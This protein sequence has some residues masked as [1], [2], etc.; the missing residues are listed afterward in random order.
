MTG[1]PICRQGPLSILEVIAVR[2]LLGK[3]LVDIREEDYVAL[4]LI[5]LPPNPEN[6]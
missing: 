2:H 3:R 4:V 1:E 6:E 5:D